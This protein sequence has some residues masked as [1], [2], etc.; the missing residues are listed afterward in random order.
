MNKKIKLSDYVAEFLSNISDFAFV[1]HGSSVVHILDSIDKRKDIRNISSQ[2]EQ[3]AS[4]AADAYSRISGKI[5]VSIATS[6]PGIINLL[7]GM[8]CSFFDSIPHFIISGAVPTNNMRDN[9]NIRQ[10]GF[11][12]ME[13]VDIVNPLT[14]YAVLLKKANMIKY[15]LE[16][17]LYFANEGRKGPVL[18]DIPDDLQRQFIDPK[19]L[20]SFKR[21][22]KNFPSISSSMLNN[23]SKTLHYSKRPLLVIG[24]GANNSKII[25]EKFIN[26]M[27]IPFVL[28]WATI[29]LFSHEHKNFVGT[30]GVAATRYGNFNVY[31]SDLLI[32]LG[33]RLSYQLTGANKKTFA[34]NAK[35]IVVDIDKYELNK[36][37]SV[38]IDF[39][40]NN[41]LEYFLKKFLNTKNT[42]KNYD[43]KKW[44][45]FCKKIKRK[46]PICNKGYYLE[47]KYVNPYVFFNEF[48]KFS[49]QNDVLIPDASANLIWAY[50][51]LRPKKGQKIFTALN[52][53]PMGYSIAA[54]VGAKFGSKNRNVI[55]FIGDGSV[56][57]NVQE[58]ETIAYNNLPVKIFIFN[59]KGYG[60]IKGTI[61]LFLGKNY[62]GV[63]PS[64]GLGIQ[65]FKKM[66]NS[67]DI[68]Y[69]KISKNKNIGSKIKNILKLKKPVICD[70]II[71][72]D[73]RVIPK[74]S[75]GKPMHL[76]SPELEKNELRSNLIEI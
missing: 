32:C 43:P 54:S 76:M 19:K 38:K 10:V 6:G 31:N 16:K 64:S 17:M 25:L 5:G 1:G 11:Q 28:T 33:T 63:D 67:Y 49:N 37:N 62:V 69:V 3:G 70:L 71:D 39:A 41:T 7:Q 13:V 75:S 57:M 66:A 46:Y 51:S 12:E 48:N 18:I 74:L 42:F 50:Q 26:K 21:P 34:P 4:L 45:S 68:K 35:I 30:F 60:L 58:L 55:A 14:K 15:E 56:S 9:K 72:P 59:N 2:N 27:Q 29:D 20:K 65:N 47:K 40:I 22:K 36:L 23:I 61:E 8:G 73:Q 53:S 52:H 44:I 24:N